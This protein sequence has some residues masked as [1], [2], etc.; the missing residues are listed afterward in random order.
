MRILAG[1]YVEDLIAFME[2]ARRASFTKAAEA[3]S[4]ERSVMSRRVAEL[5]RR[6][7]VT[8]LARSTRKV[9]LTE[10]GEA[11]IAEM[12]PLLEGMERAQDRIS[13]YARAPQGVLRVSA[14]TAFGVRFI[15]PLVPAFVAANPAISLDLSLSDMFA[16]LVGDRYD[17]AIRIGELKDSRLFVR[18][19]LVNR[20]VLVAAPGYLEKAPP[21]KTPHDLQGA[22]CLLFT[23]Y[24]EPDVWRLS[25]GGQTVSVRV[26]GNLRTDN[27]LALREMVRAGQ[28]IAN[29]AL[30]N[31]HED[32]ETGALVRVLADWD[33][34][35]TNVNFLFSGRPP[36]RKVRAFMEFMEARLRSVAPWADDVSTEIDH[37]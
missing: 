32:L 11:L 30:F 36:P 1:R 35:P 33:L 10:A 15:A 6:L 12:T 2:V 29:P 24:A 37:H 3:L 27:G 7:G 31:C 20:R 34:P 4:V 28:G 16:D 8:L 13:E 23:G 26:T 19:F 25:K 14:P 22:N 18:P 5:E 17:L 21:I 9:S